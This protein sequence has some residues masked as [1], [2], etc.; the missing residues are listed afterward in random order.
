MCPGDLPGVADVANHAMTNTQVPTARLSIGPANWPAPQPAASVGE[1]YN[2]LMSALG[3]QPNI[4]RKCFEEDAF[5]IVWD[6][7]KMPQDPTSAISTRS[8]DQVHIQLSNLSNG[9]TE[10]WVTLISFQ[11]VAIRESGISVLS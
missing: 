3:Q 11:V 7:R 9:A 2:M 4:N 6:L 1:Y 10:C 5:T 8:G